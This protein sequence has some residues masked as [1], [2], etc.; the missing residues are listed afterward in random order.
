M[1]FSLAVYSAP[2]SSQSASSALRFARVLLTQ[3]HE[4]YRVF[5]YCDGVQNGNTLPA[6]PQD[7]TNLIEQWQDLQRRHH[8]DLVICIAAAQRRGVLSTREAKRLEKPAANL[9]NGFELA[10]LGQL[11]DAIAYSERLV[12]FGG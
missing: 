5:F 10:G 2:H 11:V 1:K 7:E 8:L 6:P 9:A 4:I 12:T 3:G